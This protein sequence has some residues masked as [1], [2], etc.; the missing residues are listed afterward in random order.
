M[1]KIF[2][3]KHVDSIAKFA[4]IE[5]KMPMRRKEAFLQHVILFLQKVYAMIKKSIFKLNKNMLYLHK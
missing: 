5:L 3:K 4:E 2:E 1:T